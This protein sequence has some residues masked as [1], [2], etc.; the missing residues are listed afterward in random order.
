MLGNEGMPR[1]HPP[2]HDWREAEPR[3]HAA[4]SRQVC[5]GRLACAEEVKLSAGVRAWGA[6]CKGGPAVARKVAG[7]REPCQSKAAA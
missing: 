3:D 5:Q 7:S 1:L 6:E 4:E 2:L